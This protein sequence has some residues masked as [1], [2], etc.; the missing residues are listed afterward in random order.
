MFAF[1]HQLKDNSK[2]FPCCCFILA[3]VLT[4]LILFLSAS[5]TRFYSFNLYQIQFDCE[6]H[7]NSSERLRS[8][9]YLQTLF[10]P[11]AGCTPCCHRIDCVLWRHSIQGG[12]RFPAPPLSVRRYLH[13]RTAGYLLDRQVQ[14]GGCRVH[15]T[16]S[17]QNISLGVQLFMLAS[18]IFHLKQELSQ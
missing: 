15:S 13:A 9:F 10:A 4:I 7:F 17:N 5:F 14:P 16:D 2:V 3:L 8:D 11:S 1:L 18:T 12:N 6:I